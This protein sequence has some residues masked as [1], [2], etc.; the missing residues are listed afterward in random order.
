[1]MVRRWEVDRFVVTWM[2]LSATF[3]LMN[4]GATSERAEL[5]LAS[6][7]RRDGSLLLC[8]QGRSQQRP[9]RRWPLQ[10]I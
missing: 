1:M 7:A 4:D 5:T 10:L 2:V 3:V 9:S 8:C 6:M